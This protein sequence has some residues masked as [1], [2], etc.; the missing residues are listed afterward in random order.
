MDMDEQEQ[1]DKT[2]LYNKSVYIMLCL[3]VSPG[4]RSI[5]TLRIKSGGVPGF[6]VG[7]FSNKNVH[8]IQ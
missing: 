3:K 7:L 5:V 6:T 2:I 1:V 4:C 8:Q